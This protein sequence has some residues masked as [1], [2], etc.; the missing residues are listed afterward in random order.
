MDAAAKHLRLSMA[1]R[2]GLHRRALISVFRS[3]HHRRTATLPRVGS[4]QALSG[5]PN[6]MPFKPTATFYSPLI[7]PLVGR[8]FHRTRSTAGQDR[9]AQL[10]GVFGFTG[11]SAAAA[12]I[13]KI[14]FFI[15]IIAFVVLLILGLVV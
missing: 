14:L 4:V 15:F 10:A 3:P 6:W 9:E 7:R 12:G 11:I 1:A 8:W 2:R 13:A 5:R